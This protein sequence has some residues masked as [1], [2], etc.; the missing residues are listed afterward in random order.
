MLRA[1]RAVRYASQGD[2]NAPWMVRVSG[3]RRRDRARARARDGNVRECD[4]GVRCRVRC[5][6]A[7][8]SGDMGAGVCDDDVY[9]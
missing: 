3:V 7:T 2:S 6:R 8:V 4:A 5:L 9:G 1:P